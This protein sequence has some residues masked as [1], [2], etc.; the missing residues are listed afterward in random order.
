M[1]RIGSSRQAVRQRKVEH[2]VGHQTR[3]V[4][5]ATRLVIEA[6]FKASQTGLVDGQRIDTA[7]GILFTVE[8]PVI[9]KH[10][11]S[12]L[13]RRVRGFFQRHIHGQL[14]WRERRSTH[15]MAASSAS[16]SP[17]R[18]SASTG[19]GTTILGNAE[20]PI[21]WIAVAVDTS[22]HR[23]TGACTKRVAGISRENR[24]VVMLGG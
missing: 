11:D 16:G 9:F 13:R 22:L 7:A 2:V 23:C 3:S 14:P 17:V 6:D 19:D 4:A 24:N 20:L 8:R 5:R 12:N 21:H 1:C 15:T 18:G 10:K